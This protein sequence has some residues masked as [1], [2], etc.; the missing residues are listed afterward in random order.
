VVSLGVEI[1][2][3][4]GKMEIVIGREDPVSGIFPD[5]DLDPHEGQEAGVGRRHV[6]LVLQ[7]GQVY[8]EDLNSVNGT[9]V[10]K[11]RL[12]PGNL[13]PLNGGDELR[14]GKLVMI[15]HAG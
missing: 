4:P 7:N 6:R 9:F 11:T 10:N 8:V 12:A 2:I 1:P 13:Q 15:Y 14:L 3:P 5:I